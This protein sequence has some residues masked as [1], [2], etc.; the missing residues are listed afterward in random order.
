MRSAV[1]VAALALGALSLRLRPEINPAMA[2]LLTSGNEAR[3]K[4]PAAT[5]GVLVDTSP[6]KARVVKAAADESAEG[7]QLLGNA[8]GMALSISKRQGYILLQMFNG[9]FVAMTESWVCNVRQYN[10]VLD[11]TLFVATDRA[12]YEALTSFDTNLHV[13]LKKNEAPE[14][15]KFGSEEY[16]R[17]ML[18][19]SNLIMELLERNVTTWMVESDATWLSDPAPMVLGT[20]GDMVA[21]S[22]SGSTISQMSNGGFQLLRPTRGMKKAWRMLLERQ[23]KAMK[24][25]QDPNTKTNI[26]TGNEQHMMRTLRSELGDDLK[27]GWLSPEKFV[28][29]QYY[30]SKNRPKSPIV[31]LNNWIKGREQKIKRAKEWGHWYLED[32]H[33]CI[34]GSKDQAIHTSR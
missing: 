10:G 4:A 3:A 34:N 21:M 20:G 1:L 28:S 17:F 29:G 2:P 16:F 25:Y 8:L 30:G 18:F 24:L 23:M 13:V 14:T 7:A 26:N 31:I 5:S 27:T 11:R 33:T 15:L 12:A 22:D 19:R 6:A 9:G 32:D